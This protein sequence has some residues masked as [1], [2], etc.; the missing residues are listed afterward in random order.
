MKVYLIAVDPSRSAE[1]VSTFQD[2]NRVEVLPGVWLV[3]SALTSADDVASTIRL[4]ES[5]TVGLGI[6]VSAEF[7]S[8]YAAGSVLEKLRA[9]GER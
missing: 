1:A 9:W 4:D 7:Y 2:E 6:V 8:G 5:R 3:R